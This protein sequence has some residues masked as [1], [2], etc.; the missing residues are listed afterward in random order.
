MTLKGHAERRV[1]FC[2]FSGSTKAVSR[3][4][5]VRD[6]SFSTRQRLSQHTR[7]LRRA[8]KG[9]AFRIRKL[10]CTKSQLKTYFQL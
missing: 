5:V 3:F 1:L 2:T 8:T 9:R 6:G 4:G 7:S 10:L